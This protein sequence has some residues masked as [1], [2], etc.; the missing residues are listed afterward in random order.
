MAV[1]IVKTDITEENAVRSIVLHVQ[2]LFP[3]ANF[4]FDL[5]DC[6]NILRL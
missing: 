5:Q 1:E 3:K 2:Q 4:N 6:L